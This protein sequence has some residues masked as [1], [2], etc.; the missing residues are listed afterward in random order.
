MPTTKGA[1]TQERILR[2]AERLFAERGYD[3]VS[4]RTL[5]AGADVQLA[6][7]SYYFSNK[8]GLYRAVFQRRI[9]PI[10]A[11]RRDVL[12]RV[13]RRVGIRRPRL[14]KCSMPW[15]APGW[16]CATSAAAST[17]RG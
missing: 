11:Q 15:G 7:L 9:D 2:V 6:L 12:Q 5:A 16:N 13:M 17:T 14:R 3:G 10:S 1:R 8:L 4:M